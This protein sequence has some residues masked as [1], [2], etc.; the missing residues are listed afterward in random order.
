MEQHI[1]RKELAE[2]IG[3]T[4]TEVK[5]KDVEAIV[6][7][8]FEE[9]KNTLKAGKS[10]RVNGFGTLKVSERKAR[11]G[12]NPKTGEKIVIPATKTVT[13]KAATELKNLVK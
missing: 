4:L 12:V 13:F 7:A 9:I 3:A 11:N 8:V 5:K 1:N 6:E 10:V 2:Q